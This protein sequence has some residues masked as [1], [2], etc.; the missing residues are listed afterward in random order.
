MNVTALKWGKKMLNRI[1]I[2]IVLVM[3]SVTIAFSI[4][5]IV[6]RL[7]MPY[8][9][10]HFPGEYS[11][12]VFCHEIVSNKDMDT[13]IKTCDKCFFRLEVD[14]ELWE[15]IEMAKERGG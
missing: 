2:F 13:N 4:M 8:K 11:R 10:K 12:C 3:A 5:N 6:D 7:S 14:Y 15:I 1:L 9:L